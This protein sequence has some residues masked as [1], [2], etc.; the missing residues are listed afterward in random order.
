MRFGLYSPDDILFRLFR[1]DGTGETMVRWGSEGY[2]TGGSGLPEDEGRLRWAQMPLP[3]GS[4][5]LDAVT[6][7]TASPDD[8][9]LT[10]DVQPTPPPPYRFKSIA[11][12]GYQTCGVLLDGTPL[13]WGAR[14]VE[15]DGSEIP[16]L[17][18]KAISVGDH[19]CG[20]LDNGEAVCWDFKEE[21]P[22]TCYVKDYGGTYCR[23]DNQPPPVDVATRSEGMFATATITVLGG[24]F[25]QT[26]PAGER[27]E[28]LSVGWVHACG[29]RQ[30]GTAV[31]WGSNQYGKATPPPGERLKSISSGQSH[32]CGIRLDGTAI[33]WGKD[34]GQLTEL[35]GGPY[36]S[37]NAGKHICALGEDGSSRCWGGGGLTACLPLDSG[38]YV[39]SHGAFE[40]RSFA[41]AEDV[42]LSPPEGEKLA[43]L[44]S[45]SPH[46]ALRDNGSA[47][48]WT[49]YK[50]TGLMPP[51]AGE[52]FTSISSSAHH[53]CA[54]RPDA[55]VACWGRDRFGESSPPSGANLTHQGEPA[56]PAGQVSISAGSYHTCSLDGDGYATCW[57]PNWWTGR[58]TERFTS[59][60]GGRAHACGLRPDG[61]VL[62][63]GSDLY[64]QS[65]PPQV[66]NSFRSAAATTITADS[67]RTGLSCAGAETTMGNPLPGRRSVRVHQRWRLAYLRPSI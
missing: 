28:S 51:P 56:A 53:A 10:V 57:G 52:R 34:F 33:C 42:P 7:D 31:C 35:E 55:T 16:D 32:T 20:L 19:V 8:F 63:R 13:C 67:A 64:G 37:V 22:H 24:Y 15:G 66:R 6:L 62:C 9:R 43:A 18:F 40:C 41:E 60:N 36:I 29:L 45:G 11:V 2:V 46:C 1:D 4:Y 50:P 17:K 44:S 54:L 30:N 3:A 58:F 59:I 23:R 14:G 49:R 47:V 21:G 48:C 26:P 12:S 27:F 65:S 5:R 38:G 25:D 39:A 61:S